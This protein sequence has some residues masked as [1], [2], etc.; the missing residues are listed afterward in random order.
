MRYLF[1]ATAALCFA[2][3]AAAA[4]SVPV[5]PLG[6]TAT[7]GF[8]GYGVVDDLFIQN[9]AF[10]SSIFDGALGKSFRVSIEFVAYRDEPGDIP[11]TE[12]R[13]SRILFTRLDTGEQWGEFGGTEGIISDTSFGAMEDPSWWG[14]AIAA[15]HNLNAASGYF[16]YRLF[17]CDWQ[18]D[19][20][21]CYWSEASGDWTISKVTMSVPEPATWAMLIL[22]FGFV[23]SALRR[24]RR[25]GPVREGHAFAAREPGRRP[26]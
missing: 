6:K 19:P 7:I 22:G 20:S 21:Q 4:V 14:Y 3:S 11:F 8:H 15:G 5:V 10:S 2:S 9:A 16:S 12:S 13:A 25:A 18:N 17:E 1:A 23:G 26:R 24:Q